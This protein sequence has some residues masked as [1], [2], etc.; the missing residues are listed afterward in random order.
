MDIKNIL[1]GSNPYVQSKVDKGESSEA[2]T[3]AKAKAKARSQT[4]SGDRVSVSSDAKLVAEAAKA[5]QASP[6]VR[7]ERVEALRAQVKAGDYNPNPRRIAEKL[8][9][10]D[11]DFLR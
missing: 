10:S 2:A 7:V 5:A 4:A 3:A 6:D 8:V 11:L 9:A 1:G